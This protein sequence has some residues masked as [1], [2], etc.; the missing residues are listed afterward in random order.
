MQPQ[1]SYLAEVIVGS[2]LGL[3][4]VIGITSVV[5]V[6]IVKKVKRTPNSVYP[7]PE[8]PSDM[9][10]TYA[11]S[12]S[13]QTVSVA[14]YAAIYELRRDRGS[15][16]RPTSLRNVVVSGPSVRGRTSASEDS[17]QL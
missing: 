8:V 14:S 16:A 2:T 1:R 17:G 12:N 7:S 6:M 15:S 5:I 3:V 11:R 13:L 10:S 4:L 9:D